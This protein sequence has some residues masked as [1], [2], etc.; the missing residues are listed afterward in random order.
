MAELPGM[1]LVVLGVKDKFTNEDSPLWSPL[2]VRAFKEW[3]PRQFQYAPGLRN[4]LLELDLDIVHTHGIWQ[5]PSMAV[6]AWYR[7]FQR[8]YMISPHGMLDPWAVKNSAW[9]KRLAWVF[10]ERDHLKNARCLRAL[11]PAEA[12]AF[13]GFGL[14]NPL[15]VIPNGVDLPL[16]AGES[17]QKAE[18]SP[19]AP[20]AHGRKVLLSLGRIHPKKGLVHLL[21]A[22]KAILDSEPSTRKSW[23]LAIAGWDQG[24]H[25][26]ELRKLSAAG[27][28]EDSICFLGP[29]FG[30]GKA[31]CYRNCDAFI[32]PS[33]SEGLPV[34]VL[35]AWAYEK[36]VLITPECNLPEGF[37]AQA[38]L[39]V[40][41]GSEGI[42][43]GLR[44]FF[45]MSPDERQAMGRNGRALVKDR[46]AWPK[47]VIDM[48]SVYEW[49]L[50][51]GPKPE[52][53]EM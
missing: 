7:K 4:A 39:R 1:E 48:R 50:G 11:C 17:K 35:E 16:L 19:F 36:P 34:V 14:K 30:A 53:V 33:L 12:A 32:L 10:Y 18:E 37:A 26:D 20:F 27:G 52:C 40:D 13:R 3:G 41:P 31:A 42:R 24:G 46:F 5:Y 21:H 22:W 45:E 28:M 23:V 43:K 51:G 9:K 49:M 8:P 25:E 29:Q 15:C 47:I 38:A 44:Q 2:Q 6:S